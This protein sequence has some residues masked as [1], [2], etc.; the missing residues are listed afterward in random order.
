MSTAP[1]AMPAPEAPDEAAHRYDTF[2]SGTDPQKYFNCVG[3]LNVRVIGIS[4][5]NPQGAVV[6][7]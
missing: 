2:L 6:L 1:E 5:A 7:L 3:R 4:A